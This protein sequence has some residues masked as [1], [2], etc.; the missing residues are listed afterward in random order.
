MRQPIRFVAMREF[1][2]RHV[3]CFLELCGRKLPFDRSEETRDARARLACGRDNGL[4]HN[5]LSDGHLARQTEERILLNLAGMKGDL[6]YSK[7]RK[8]QDAQR[9][10]L[11]G[12]DPL[13]I[14]FRARAIALE[15]A[16][17]SVWATA[18]GNRHPLAR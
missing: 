7:A 2:E 16:T 10:E 11:G 9:V 13:L 18:N 4:L 12:I 1:R 8:S 3:T 14:I 5:E 6:S 17:V 15:I